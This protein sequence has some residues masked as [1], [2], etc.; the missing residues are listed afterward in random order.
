[1]TIERVED[2]QGW[3]QA[4]KITNM[5][6]ERDRFAKHYRLRDR[7]QGAAIFRKT[8]GED[9]KSP[10]PFQERRGGWK[11]LLYSNSSNPGMRKAGAQIRKSP[12]CLIASGFYILQLSCH[13]EH[14]RFELS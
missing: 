6:S 11:T 4:H 3:Q 8:N 14:M 12:A 7:I 9:D 2:I 1:M 13:L 5:V 10:P